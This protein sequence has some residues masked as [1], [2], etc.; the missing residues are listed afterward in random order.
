MNRK[1]LLI[2]FLLGQV[3]CFGQQQESLFTYED[4]NSMF[5]EGGTC[6]EVGSIGSEDHFFLV[7]AFDF[8]YDWFAYEFRP[9][10]TICKCKNIKT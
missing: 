1:A 7:S 4:P 6:L 8:S 5:S 9:H 10:K 3:F 2:V